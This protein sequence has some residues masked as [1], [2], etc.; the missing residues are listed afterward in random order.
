MFLLLIGFLQKGATH[1]DRSQFAA[2]QQGCFT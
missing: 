2:V 1:G